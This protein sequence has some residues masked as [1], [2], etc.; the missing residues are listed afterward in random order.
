[1]EKAQ[2]QS[3]RVEGSFQMD[4]EWRPYDK[5]VSAPIEAQ[6]SERIYTLLGSKHRLKR[7]EIRV[8]KVQPFEGE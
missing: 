8:A 5:V 2:A 6:A 3:Y 1:M 7:R 4:G